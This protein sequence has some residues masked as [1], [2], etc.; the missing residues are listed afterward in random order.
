MNP[1]IYLPCEIKN[2]E[3]DSRLMVAAHALHQGYT[4]V[5]GQQ[6]AFARNTPTLP[7]GVMLVKTVNAIQAEFMEDLKA[8]GHIVAGSDEE[9]LAMASADGFLLPVS[10]RA[11]K[12]ADVFLANSAQHRD[13]LL[14][15]YPDLKDKITVTGNPRIDL[16]SPA[17]RRKFQ[18][19]ADAIR[20][21]MGPFVLFN[22]NY[23]S[24]NSVW[25]DFKEAAK[26][27][28]QAGLLDRNDPASVQRYNDLLAFEQAN[29]QALLDVMKS[30]ANDST[31]HRAVIRPHPGEKVDFWQRFTAHA[32]ITVVPRSHHIPWLMA[33]DLVV[34]TCCTTGMEALALGTPAINVSPVPQN[35]WYGL[36][37][38]KHV[39][40][41]ITDSAEAAQAVQTYLSSRSGPLADQE[42]YYKKLGDWFPTLNT[43]DAAKRMADALIAA[44]KA[45]GAHKPVKFTWALR[46][47]AFK[48]DVRTDNQRDKFSVTPQEVVDG[49]K[50]FM[51]ADKLERT[52]DLKQLDDSLF[53]LQPA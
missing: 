42:G 28:I 51:T 1:I 6:W 27:A 10:P 13:A 11:V 18:P 45:R 37:L 15:A 20:R 39:N 52:F 43:R 26:I 46:G 17:L 14:G 53:L 41:C 47:E 2:R 33:A 36:Y 19:E 40:C 49:L 38:M 7:E 44:L 9:V 8:T 31:T 12:A 21:K 16:M 22:T 29:M 30:V 5:L 23:G 4:V 34:H 32:R 24:T 48:H 50:Y 25:G 35:W 3:F